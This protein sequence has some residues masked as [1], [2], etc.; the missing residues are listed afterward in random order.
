MRRRRIVVLTLLSH[1][2]EGSGREC[3]GTAVRASD[4]PLP[5][6]AVAT[7]CF[8]RLI[9]SIPNSTAKVLAGLSDS[10]FPDRSEATRQDRSCHVPDRKQP[11]GKTLE[12][13]KTSGASRT[14]GFK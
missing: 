12:I 11:P 13:T 4:D 14:R 8:S 9:Q 2:E 1:K 7:Q 3:I 6:R 10:I 5:H